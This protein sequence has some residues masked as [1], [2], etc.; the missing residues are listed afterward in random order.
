M[1]EVRRESQ[2][3]DDCSSCTDGNDDHVSFR[4]MSG[5][6]QMPSSRAAKKVAAK[7]RLFQSKVRTQLEVRM[8]IRKKKINEQDRQY[9]LI[10]QCPRTKTHRAPSFAQASG[11][12]TKM[13]MPSQAKSLDA[14]HATRN[15]NQET[16][17]TKDTSSCVTLQVSTFQETN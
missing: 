7:R 16:S 8:M 6:N 1:H 17:Q 11:E 9:F 3:E 15:Y 13:T 10:S 12:Y 5:R 4:R 14:L 2:N